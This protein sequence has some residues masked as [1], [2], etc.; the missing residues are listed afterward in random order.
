[1]TKIFGGV[2]GHFKNPFG[3][4]RNKQQKQQQSYRKPFVHLWS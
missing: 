2:K 3:V 1:M 4:N